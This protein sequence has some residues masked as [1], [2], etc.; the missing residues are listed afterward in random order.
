MKHIPG[1][2]IIPSGRC[3]FLLEGTDS[4][5]VSAWVRKIRDSAPEGIN[6]S[7]S[8]LRYW[9]RHTYDI[10]GDEY[11]EAAAMLDSLLES[12]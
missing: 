1:L 10:N 9:V 6:Y 2:I 4:E 12:K 11:Q 7:S 3:P 5:A 8:A